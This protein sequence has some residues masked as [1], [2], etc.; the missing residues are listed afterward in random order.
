[1]AAEWLRVGHEAGTNCE[2]DFFESSK[3]ERMKRKYALAV[4][5]THEQAL[6]MFPEPSV[7]AL[8]ASGRGIRPSALRVVA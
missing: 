2:V 3:D 5:E 4:A 1:M 6:A 8:Q 7:Q